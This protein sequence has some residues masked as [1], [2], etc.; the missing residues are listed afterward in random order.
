MRL[1]TRP[2]EGLGNGVY[3]LEE[4]RQNG[5]TARSRRTLYHERRTPRLLCRWLLQWI[6]HTQPL[7]SGCCNVLLTGHQLLFFTHMPPYLSLLAHRFLF[8]AFHYIC[9]CKRDSMP[10]VSSTIFGE[11][12]LIEGRPSVHYFQWDYRIQ[13][14]LI[15]FLAYL[16]L[17]I[18]IAD[19]W[20]WHQRSYHR[21]KLIS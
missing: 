9:S 20:M 19:D 1:R 10:A 7:P 8:W 21:W 16:L 12:E 3:K 2:Y 14:I 5:V 18:L 15:S 13:N 6:H 11:N 17:Y 4:G